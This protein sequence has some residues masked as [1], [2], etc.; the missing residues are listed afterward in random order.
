[1]IFVL[2]SHADDN[3]IDLLST[4][5]VAASVVQFVKAG[6]SF[7][8]SSHQLYSHGSLR[9]NVDSEEAVN[10]LNDL[11]KDVKSSIVDING[12]GQ[13]SNS[14]ARKAICETGAALVDDLLIRFNALRI[15]DRQKHRRWKSFRQA[16]KSTYSK[17]VVDNLA[18]KLAKCRDELNTH[19][20]HSIT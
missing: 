16:M 12:L 7:V 13:L 10:R 19:S 9:S 15:D 18:Q 8:S 2:Y 3:I 5:G 4:L 20:L 6:G 17:R 14:K 11:T 1:M